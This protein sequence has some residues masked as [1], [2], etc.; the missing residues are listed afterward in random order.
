MV[1]PAQQEVLCKGLILALCILYLY[2][3]SLTGTMGPK[4]EVSISNGQSKWNE[5]E[6]VNFAW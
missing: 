6:G 1:R 4:Y 3:P 5:G 2:L